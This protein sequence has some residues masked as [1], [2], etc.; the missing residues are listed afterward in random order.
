[1]VLSNKKLKLKLRAEIVESLTSAQQPDPNESSK[2]AVGLNSQR[3]SLKQLL[4]SVTQKPILSKREKKRFRTHDSLEDSETVNSKNRGG[5]SKNV[6]E[7][8]K[9]GGNENKKKK[10]KTNGDESESLELVGEGENGEKKKRKKKDKEEEEGDEESVDAKEARKLKRKKIKKKQMKKKQR[11]AN[12]NE[13]KN[14]GDD[15]VVVNEE[16]NNSER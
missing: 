5:D 1:M 12:K 8:N 15:G 13:E 14:K 11:K 2:A 3:H 9:E 16:S 10:R 7:E 6:E 4:N